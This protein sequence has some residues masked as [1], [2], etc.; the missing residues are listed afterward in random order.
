MFEKLGGFISTAQALKFL[1]KNP[2]VA[3]ILGF[4]NGQVPTQ[5]TFNYFKKTHG[6]QML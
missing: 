2:N 1:E 4:T 5:P 6:S 3:K